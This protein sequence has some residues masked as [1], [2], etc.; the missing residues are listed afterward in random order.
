MLIA[1]LKMVLTK[2]LIVQL[3]RIVSPRT[4]SVTLAQRRRAMPTRIIFVLLAQIAKLLVSELTFA[5]SSSLITF[6]VSLD[7]MH[8][9][10]PVV[11]AP[12]SVRD[13]LRVE[14]PTRR[15]VEAPI[16][17]RLLVHCLLSHPPR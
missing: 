1:R 5:R 15:R 17:R 11:K 2:M 6:C 3:V 12:R 14:A 8:L 16:P 13:P 9:H 4:I 10:I 7:L